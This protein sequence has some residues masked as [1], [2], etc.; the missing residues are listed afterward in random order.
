M[1]TKT[2]IKQKNKNRK[3]R[4]YLIEDEV[5]KVIKT[6][7]INGQHSNRDMTM[8]LGTSI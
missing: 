6:S 2:P 1:R 7:C 8:I 3:T 5:A 4:E